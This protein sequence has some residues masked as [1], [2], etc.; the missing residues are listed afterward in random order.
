[1][2]HGPPVGPAP[3]TR[4]NERLE[5]ALAARSTRLERDQSRHGIGRTSSPGDAVEPQARGLVPGKALHGE[6]R[7]GSSATRSAAVTKAP[8][9]R[10]ACVIVF[11][12]SGNSYCRH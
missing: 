6:H 5:R 7:G 2:G 4:M 12:P 11:L 1:M 10:H 3:R 9:S 8:H